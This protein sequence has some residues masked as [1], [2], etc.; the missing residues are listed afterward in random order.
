MSG[1]LKVLRMKSKKRFI[2]DEYVALFFK[3]KDN[4]KIKR[5]KTKINKLRK[6]FN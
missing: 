4:T 2:L 5:K 6:F 1:N 3:I